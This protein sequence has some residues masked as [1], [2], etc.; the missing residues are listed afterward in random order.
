MCMSE[1]GYGS[2]ALTVKKDQNQE[3]RLAYRLTGEELQHSGIS[4]VSECSSIQV[5][6]RARL[7]ER[8]LTQK[9]KKEGETKG[10]GPR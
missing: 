6:A 2:R 3:P 8:D 9:K 10:I 1:L 4:F 5:S 7:V